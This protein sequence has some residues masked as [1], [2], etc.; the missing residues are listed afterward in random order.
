MSRST[1]RTMSVGL[2]LSLVIVAPASAGIPRVGDIISQ[3][4]AEPR[5]VR[6]SLTRSIPN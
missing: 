5:L 1:F 3:S 6:G 2:P 4:R